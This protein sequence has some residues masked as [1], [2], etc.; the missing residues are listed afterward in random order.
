MQTNE[1]TKGI[2]TVILSPAIFSF[3]CD[4]WPAE[5]YAHYCREQ[6]EYQAEVV[7]KSP[8]H[9]GSFAPLPLQTVDGAL[10]ALKYCEEMLDPKPEGY[11]LTTSVHGNYLG[12]P[13]YAPI[14]EDCNRREVVLFVHPSETVMPTL[15]QDKFVFSTIEYPQETSRMLMEMIDEGTFVKYPKIKWIFC[16]NGGNFPFIF[17]RI[18]RHMTAQNSVGYGGIKA[19]NN[20]YDRIGHVNNGMTLQELIR[21]SNIYI[22]GAQGTPAQ[23]T[24]LKSLGI[25]SDKQLCGSDLPFTVVGEKTGTLEGELHAAKDSGLYSDKELKN[26]YYGNALKLF[27]R[28]AKAWK[29]ANISS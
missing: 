4:K 17:Q 9:R 15:D 22:E 19:M 10:E 13:F 25:S 2:A 14:L 5:R 6:T 20:Q 7:R 11:A 1:N 12:N 16:H 8:T 3:M 29:E 18:I 26:I 27:P 23:H 28:I 21:S 24:V